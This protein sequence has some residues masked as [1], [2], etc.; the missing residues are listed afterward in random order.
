M[1]HACAMTEFRKGERVRSKVDGLYGV[2]VD[3]RESR[4]QVVW[5]V[6]LDTP[7]F[8]PLFGMLYDYELEKA[9]DGEK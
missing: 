3:R 7:D 6:Q 5:V 8:S 1:I 2:I 9:D 4:G